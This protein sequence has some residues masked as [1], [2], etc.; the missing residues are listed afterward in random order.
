MIC[1]HRSSK[2]VTL[3]VKNLT[4]YVLTVFLIPLETRTKDIFERYSVTMEL[5]GV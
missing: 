1:R 2:P 3:S 4:T 5:F